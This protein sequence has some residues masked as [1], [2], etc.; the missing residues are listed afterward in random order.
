M[1]IPLVNQTKQGVCMNCPPDSMD[2]ASVLEYI[3][4]KD[5]QCMEERKRAADQ[6]NAQ[7]QAERLERVEAMDQTIEL[8][9]EQLQA[10][11]E[12]STKRFN[13]SLDCLKEVI[14]GEREDSRA[15]AA[16]RGS[17]P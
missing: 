5:L 4:R 16:S 11:R 14:Q 2:L 3:E 12:E 8:M 1:G 7:L 10:E 17:L 15:S 13:H 9:R 6:A